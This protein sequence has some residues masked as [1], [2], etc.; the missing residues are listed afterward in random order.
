M[1]RPLQY[2]FADKAKCYGHETRSINQIGSKTIFL[3]KASWTR[4]MDTDFGTMEY[5]P[6]ALYRDAGYKVC[7]LGILVIMHIN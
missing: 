3:N 7:F 1:T 4:I 5:W 2:A 6:W